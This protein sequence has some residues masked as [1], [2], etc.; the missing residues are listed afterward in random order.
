MIGWVLFE[1]EQLAYAWRFIGVMLGLGG[2]GFA[3]QQS[4]YD[5]STNVV[6]L[7]VLAICAT[8]LP[9]IMLAYMKGKWRIAGVI[10]VP[11]I[12]FLFMVLS[13][14]YLVNDT[15]NPF[16]YFRF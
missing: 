14:A 5:L 16:L 6:L 2:H 11:F 15:Y 13:T 8:P 12:Y 1:M 7:V 4:L 3:D 9:G 10:T